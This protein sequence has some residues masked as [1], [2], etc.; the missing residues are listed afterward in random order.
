MNNILNRANLTLVN[1]LLKCVTDMINES[2]YC[3]RVIEREFNR[4]LVMTK[5]DFEDFSKFVVFWISEKPFKEG[6]VKVQYHDHITRKY[7]VPVHQDQSGFRGG[8]GGHALP[9]FFGITCFYCNHFEELQTVL[10]EVELIINNAP[11][12]TITQILSKHV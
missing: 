11:L 9:L 5:K 6:D 4:P 1:M 7:R 2:E 10:F 3:R 12:T 8:R